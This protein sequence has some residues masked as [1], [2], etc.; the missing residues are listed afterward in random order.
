MAKQHLKLDGIVHRILPGMCAA[1][2]ARD[3]L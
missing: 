1:I 3:R 2:Y